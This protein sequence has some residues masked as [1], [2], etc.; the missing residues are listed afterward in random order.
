MFKYVI[1]VLTW[2]IN[3]LYVGLLFYVLSLYVNMLLSI[4]TCKYKVIQI[5]Q[6]CKYP[7][8]YNT[9]EFYSTIVYQIRMITVPRMFTYS[10]KYKYVNIMVINSTKTVRL[11]SM[12][13]RKICSMID[14][15]NRNRFRPL[16]LRLH[17]SGVYRGHPGT[18]S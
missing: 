5:Y 13:N 6:K 7:D 4:Y 9:W 16:V 1:S 17:G 12:I 14:Y 10:T 15:E 2:N 8:K 18:P 3:N 11:W